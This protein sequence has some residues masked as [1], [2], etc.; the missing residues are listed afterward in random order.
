MSAIVGREGELQALEQFLASDRSPRAFVLTGGPGIGKTTLWDSGV[1]LG[2]E[3]GLRVLTARASGADTKLS[4]AVLIDLLDGVGDEELATLP[5]PQ[6]RALEVAL[7]RAEPTGTPPETHA[8][9]L[10]LL[11]V[12]R[13][14]AARQPLLVALDDVQWL[15]RAS[16]DAL[17]YAARRLVDEPAAFLLARRP[18][19]PS[20]VERALEAKALDRLELQPVS[21]G[22]IRRIL[23]ERLG[24]ALPRHLLR[25]LYDATLG[26][27]L[28]AVELG[29]KVMQDGLPAI[30]EDLPVPDA[31][32]DL[33]GTRVAGLPDG[34]RHALLAV[35]LSP[36][37][38]VGQLAGLADQEVI[39]AAVESGVLVVDRDEI[40][41]SHP[42][43]AAAAVSHSDA[44]ERRALHRALAGVVGEGELQTRHLALAA[45]RPDAELAATVAAAAEAA[46]HRGAPE[47]AVELAEHALRLTPHDHPDRLDRALELGGYLVVA[48][49]KKR[50]RDLLE[51]LIESFPPGATRAKAWLLLTSGEISGNED[52]MRY[53]EQALAESGGDRRARASVLADLAENVAAVRVERI[54][55]AEGWAVEALAATPGAEPDLERRALYG[56]AWAR[57][58]GGKPIDDLWEQFRAA[59]ALPFYIAYSPERIA[60]QRL[61]W[62]GE[63]AAARAVLGRLLAEAD[64]RGEPSSY[65]LQRL[66]LCELE[67]RAGGWEAAARYLDEWAESSDR[68]LLLWP[69]YERCRA[70]LAAGRGEVPD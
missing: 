52:I 18:G 28:F 10:A 61:V 25:R 54:A 1:E 11:N 4:F 65:A 47:A 37:L 62:R 36:T 5:P 60:G 57:S 32:E 38:R 9:A 63:I 44:A 30:G 35:A 16:E 53:L 49:E 6:R 13:E 3:R 64:E 50:V 31:V 22:A 45:A 24:L 51:P 39:D 15:D 17:A 34:V 43:L 21:L 70:L 66:H 46:S 14:A 68:A 12:L 27:P 19:A 59:S 42:L 58:L 40:R 29:R 8:I 41:A 48:G 26:Y 7:F 33:L 2:R 23:S 67:L 56:L 20:E 69:M 55:E